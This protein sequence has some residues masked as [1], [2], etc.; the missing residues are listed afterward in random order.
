MGLFEVMRLLTRLRGFLRL[1]TGRLGLFRDF[2]EDKFILDDDWKEPVHSR[3]FYR[4]FE[5]L[6]DWDVDPKTVR[7]DPNMSLSKRKRCQLEGALFTIWIP[8]RMYGVQLPLL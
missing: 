6:W 1:R 8:L 2:V 4:G 7:M 3:D 5:Y